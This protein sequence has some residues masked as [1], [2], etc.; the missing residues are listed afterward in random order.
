MKKCRVRWASFQALHV[1][2]DKSSGRSD[3]VALSKP[4]FRA[5]AQFRPFDLRPPSVRRGLHRVYAVNRESP[6]PQ[7]RCTLKDGSP[8]LCAFE[9]VEMA[10]QATSNDPRLQLVQ[11]RDLSSEEQERVQTALLA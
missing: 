9:T 3:F 8:V 11:H 7:G 1:P 10:I 6:S 4:H 2:V 5:M